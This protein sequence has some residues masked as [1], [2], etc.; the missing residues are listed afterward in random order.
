M[1]LWGFFVYLNTAQDACCF[2]FSLKLDPVTLSHAEKE[3]IPSTRSHSSWVQ[4]RCAIS[5]SSIT[6]PRRFL[7][8]ES[9]L[10]Y[11]IKKKN[12]KLNPK[13]L[14]GTALC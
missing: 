6:S 1:F 14:E 12:E 3:A 13:K 9:V 4:I 10:P 2:L 11:Y 7:R 8:T 5:S